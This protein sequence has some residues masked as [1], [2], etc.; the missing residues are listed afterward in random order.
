MDITEIINKRK[1]LHEQI[2]KLESEMGE[3]KK[4]ALNQIRDYVKELNISF[5]E[6]EKIFKEEKLST[7]LIQ[8]VKYR[9]PKTPI[10]R[11]K[12]PYYDKIGNRW[13]N[14][15]NN[16]PYWFDI[17]HADTY[18]REGRK[19][20][21]M[22][23]LA[24]EKRGLDKESKPMPAAFTEA[25]LKGYKDKADQLTKL[26]NAKNFDLLNHHKILYRNELHQILMYCSEEL[27]DY[28]LK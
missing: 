22:V 8:E 6:I 17:E 27:E 5:I 7:T 9:G 4:V 1:S 18:L 23:R 14:G 20:S 10:D 25:Q 2:D 19:H 13:Y 24:L 26:F 15:Y 12:Y 11:S 28:L 3:I 16:I 21:K